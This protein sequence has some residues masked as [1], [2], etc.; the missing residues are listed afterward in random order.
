MENGV[1]NGAS[2]AYTKHYKIES[3]MNVHTVYTH[4]HTYAMVVWN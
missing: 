2:V 1:R 4:M 3:L